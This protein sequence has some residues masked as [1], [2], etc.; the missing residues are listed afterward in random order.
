[1]GLGGPEEIAGRRSVSFM[2]SKCETFFLML[3]R[4]KVK[5]WVAE[6][7]GGPSTLIEYSLESRLRLDRVISLH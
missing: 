4:E 2:D 7:G 6:S 5:L 1:V 3:R